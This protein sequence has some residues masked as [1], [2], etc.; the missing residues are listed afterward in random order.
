MRGHRSNAQWPGGWL[1]RFDPGAVWIGGEKVSLSKDILWQEGTQRKL[2][3]LSYPGGK[4]RMAA[5]II[6]LLPPHTV[7]VE[8]FCGAASVFW[9]KG[10]PVTTNSQNY[11]EVLNDLDENIAN[12]FKIL[13]DNPEELIRRLVFTPYARSSHADARERIGADVCDVQKAVDY[14]VLSQQSFG[15]RYNSSFGVRKKGDNGSVT[16]C[17][18]VD[19]LYQYVERLRRTVVESTCALK[20]ISRWDS[21]QTFFYVDPPYPFETQHYNTSTYTQDDFAAL[22]DL[23]SKC[24]GSVVLSCMPNDAVPDS[25]HSVDIVSSRSIKKQIGTKRKQTVEKLWIVDRSANIPD[26]LQRAAQDAQANIREKKLTLF[27]V[28]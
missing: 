23:L 3:P 19:R 22:V 21:P 15:S 25:W 24:K 2:A 8:P 9:R 13:R 4:G 26:N 1:V 6:P 28:G 16:W 17:N 10:L 11:R 20:C 7:Y 27:D 18:K 14:F 12:F 5:K